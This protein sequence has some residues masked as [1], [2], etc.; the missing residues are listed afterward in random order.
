MLFRGIKGVYSCTNSNCAH[1][2]S[3]E[4]LTLGEIFLSDGVLTCPHC[5]SVVYVLYNDRRC[6]VLFFKGYVFED[7]L[8]NQRNTYLWRDAGQILD[9]RLKEVHLFIS[10]ENYE[11][12]NKQTIKP[13]YLDVKSGFIYFSKPEKQENLL[14]LY[15]SNYQLKARPDIMT[16][17]N[18]HTAYTDSPT[19]NYHR[20]VLAVISHFKI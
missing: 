8:K 11:P 17:L 9:N 3:H 6:G 19:I 4:K 20:T 10:P 2:H 12:H 15:Y 16:F 1:S 5:H 18:V 13:C 7:D 14:K